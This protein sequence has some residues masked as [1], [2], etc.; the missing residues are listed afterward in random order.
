MPIMALMISCGAAA[1]L[2]AFE[3][4]LVKDSFETLSESVSWRV[5]YPVLLSR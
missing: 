2:S 5:V 3:I 1:L 4:S